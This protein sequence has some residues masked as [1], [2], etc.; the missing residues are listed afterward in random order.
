MD[1]CPE[2][3]EGTLEL[4]SGQRSY[5]TLPMDI[6]LTTMIQAACHVRRNQF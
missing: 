5:M 3:L 2:A 1:L 6:R 4:Y